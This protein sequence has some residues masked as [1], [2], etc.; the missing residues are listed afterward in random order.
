MI[1][2]PSYYYLI[3]TIFSDISPSQAN[4]ISSH[5]HISWTLFLFSFWMGWGDRILQKETNQSLPVSPQRQNTHRKAKSRGLKLPWE[6]SLH[7]FFAQRSTPT[8]A[9]PVHSLSQFGDLTIFRTSM[10]QVCFL[11][12]QQQVC[13]QELERYWLLLCLDY[14]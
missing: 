4:F 3:Q 14:H 12:M 6:I 11:D 8:L 10:D 5:G 2:K 13:L 7:L 1:T 9:T